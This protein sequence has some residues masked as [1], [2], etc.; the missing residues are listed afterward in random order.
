MIHIPKAPRIRDLKKAYSY[1]FTSKC[2]H[3]MLFSNS[4]IETD[5]DDVGKFF[6]PKNF[7][8]FAVNKDRGYDL[9]SYENGGM[10]KI[11]EYPYESIRGS[12]G[13]IKFMTTFIDFYGKETNVR[14]SFGKRGK[15]HT[16]VFPKQQFGIS[17]IYFSTANIDHNRVTA[18]KTVYNNGMLSSYLMEHHIKSW[19]D[20][21]GYKTCDIL[22]M[23]Q[24]DYNIMMFEVKLQLKKN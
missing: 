11:S 21:H 2:G 6:R 10:A 13:Y 22:N 14:F 5:T 12:C 24:E 9:R 8:G 17:H 1:N 3:T 19:M 20:N 7:T 15:L 18:I 16:M 23:S 4:P